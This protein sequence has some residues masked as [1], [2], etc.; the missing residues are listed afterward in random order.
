MSEP[1]VEVAGVAPTVVVEVEEESSMEVVEARASVER[2]MGDQAVRIGD[3]P[4]HEI[5]EERTGAEKEGDSPFKDFPGD[6]F[7]KVGEYT[8]EETSQSPSTPLPENPAEQTPSS[9]EPRTKR[10]KIPAGRTDLPW[11]RK[12]IALKSKTSPSSQQTSQKEPCQPTRKSYRLAAQGV[13]RT[14]TTKQGPPVI[15]EILSSS[16]GSPIKTL[17]TAAAPQESPILESEHAS[18]ENSP[19]QTPT[20]WPVLKRKVEITQSP[21]PKPAAEPSAERAKSEVAPSPK[22]EKFLK[23]GV[24]RGKRWG[25][26]KNRGWRC[27]WIS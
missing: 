18:T 17:E 21:S 1:P 11:V 13:V 10:I 16:E 24:V 12:L 2:E 26:S 23:M 6:D 8:P 27:S 9:A 4:V 3:K 15:E 22:L 5:M 19:K 25:I 20:S 14:S 7:E